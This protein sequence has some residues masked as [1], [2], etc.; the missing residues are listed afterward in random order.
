MIGFLKACEG[1]DL[2]QHFL[3]MFLEKHKGA[4][5]QSDPLQYPDVI[6][7]YMRTFIH[8]KDVAYVNG[9]FDKYLS[10]SS[11]IAKDKVVLLK[12]WDAYALCASSK[13]EVCPYCHIVQ[14]D[15]YVSED[16]AESYR[17]NIDHYYP[18]AEFPFLALSIGNFIPCCEKCNGPQMKASTRF[19][20]TPHMHPLVD[21]ENITFRLTPKALDMD[22]KVLALQAGKTSYKIE[23]IASNGACPKVANSLATFQLIARYQVCVPDA[24]LVAKLSRRNSRDKMLPQV[25]EN[26]DFGDDQPLGFDATDDSYKNVLMGKLKL[27]IAR[28]YKVI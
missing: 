20:L 28:Q 4:I 15:T 6:A 5:C 16:G 21:P 2:V 22:P 3:V 8:A 10:Y 11:F 24:L 1:P 13:V 9:L 17:P 14:V 27:D 19:D 18:K 25:L 23:L 7:D 26:L 12:K